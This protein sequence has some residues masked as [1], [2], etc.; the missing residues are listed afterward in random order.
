VQNVG[1]YGQEVSETIVE[2]RALEVDTGKPILF[3]NEA[4][5]FGY[6]SSIFNS[7]SEG[8]YFITGV[9]FKLR[10]NGK[11]TMGHR[12]LANHLKEIADFTIE[13]VRD[14]VIAVRAGKGLLVRRGHERFRCAGSFFKNPILLEENF[15]QIEERVLK[16][17]ARA[18][19]SWPLGSGEVKIS[20]AGLIQSAGFRQGHRKGNVG[21][22]PR[23]AL[24]VIAY[25]RATAQEIIEFA[26]EVQGEV[27]EKF[28]ILLKPEVR[29]VGFPPSALK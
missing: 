24:I 29:L 28:G 27:K 15:R 2:V 6:R 25:R 8:K 20:A 21:L 7:A 26:R 12:D 3:S 16:Q 13:H 1:A 23:H 18:Y 14:S 10:K 22:S 11:P 5:G 9:T 4:C 19:W 17:G